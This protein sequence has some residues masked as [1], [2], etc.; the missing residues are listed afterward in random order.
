[1]ANT[2]LRRRAA[3]WGVPRQIPARRYA[4]TGMAMT[5]SRRI[6]S[7]PCDHLCFA[8]HGHMPR[9]P[10]AGNVAFMVFEAVGRA[11]PDRVIDAPA[12]VMPPRPVTSASL[13]VSLT[14]GRPYWN[15]PDPR[16][17]AARRADRQAYGYDDLRKDS[18]DWSDS[19]GPFGEAS[20]AI[21]ERRRIRSIAGTRITNM[22]GCAPM[23]TPPGWNPIFNK[24]EGRINLVLSRAHPA[25]PA[26]LA[27]R[28]VDLIEEDI[29][30]RA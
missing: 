19:L 18:A 1:M 9:Q 23:G 20:T 26:E 28:R 12:A 14:G 22:W 8:H 5:L 17:R 27:H 4:P 3:D 13:Q 25:I 15:T 30:D 24:F 16:L 7:N 2:V 21:P 29:F 6:P 11:E 10:R